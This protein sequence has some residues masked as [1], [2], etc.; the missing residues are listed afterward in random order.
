MSMASDDTDKNADKYE[1]LFQ[2]GMK[3]HRNKEYKIAI[4]YFDQAL[5]IDPNS[6]SALNA[7]GIALYQMGQF[8]K[9]TSIFDQILTIN[10]SN[11]EALKNWQTVLKM[12]S[13][14]IKKTE[15]SSKT[16]NCA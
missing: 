12:H 9:A 1:E 4:S 2:K 8:D 10:P 7:K 14:S 5:S 15:Q 13:S 6:E 11:R 16:T 3:Y